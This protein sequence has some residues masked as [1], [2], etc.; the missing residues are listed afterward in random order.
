MVS[1]HGNY[2]VDIGA[3]NGVVHRRAPHGYHVP[4]AKP[5]TAVFLV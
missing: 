4:M 3:I 5:G 1:L 2:A